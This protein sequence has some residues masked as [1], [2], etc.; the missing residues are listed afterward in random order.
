MNNYSYQSYQGSRQM[1]PN[2]IPSQS[3][4]PPGVSGVVQGNIFYAEYILNQNIICLLLILLNG[5][6]AFLKEH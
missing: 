6:I 4:S 1:E 2:Y 5:E 3:S